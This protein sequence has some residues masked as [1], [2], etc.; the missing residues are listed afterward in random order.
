MLLIDSLR[1]KRWAVIF[2]IYLRYLLGGTFVYAGLGKAMGGRFMPAGSLQLPPTGITIDI[3]FE[4][5][6][7]TGL[8]WQFLGWGQVVA[9]FFLMTQRWS[10]LGALLFLPVSLNIFVITLSMDFHGTPVITGLLV[11]AN[12]GLLAWDYRRLQVLLVPNRDVDI[13]L[14]LTSDQAGTPYYWEVLGCLLFITSLC[15][16]NRLDTVLWFGVCFLLGLLGLAGHGAYRRRTQ[17][18]S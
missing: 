9:G 1:T 5:L 13:P 6:Y 17:K 10:T 14:R 3:F 2:V 11:L 12:L 18:N 7:R 4:T 16:G 8:W 15:F